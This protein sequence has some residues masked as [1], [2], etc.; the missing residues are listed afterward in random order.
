[1]NINQLNVGLNYKDIVLIPKKG[2]ANS[3]DNVDVS[4]EFLGKRYKLSIVPANMSCVIDFSLAEW[5]SKNNYFYILH[6]FYDYDEIFKWVV[7][8]NMRI[9]NNLKI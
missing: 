8:N 5:F 9:N 1:M 4:C 6:R 2:I 7:N 3:R